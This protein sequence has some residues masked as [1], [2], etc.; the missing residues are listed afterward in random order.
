MKMTL[1][2]L[3]ENKSLAVERR[4]RNDEE[5]NN[6]SVIVTNQ[7]NCRNTG[8]GINSSVIDTN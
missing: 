5:D 3:V 8:E 7:F 2:W 1:G 6:L 4:E